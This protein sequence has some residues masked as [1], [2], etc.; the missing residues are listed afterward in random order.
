VKFIHFALAIALMAAAGTFAYH[1]AQ[2]VS[3]NYMLGDIEMPLALFALLCF[4]VGALFTALL[5]VPHLL[6][7][8][9]RIRRANRACR[10]QERELQSLRKMPLEGAVTAE[11]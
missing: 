11:N 6:R 10:E 4:V 7:S 5:M 9:Q 3:L 2:S 1:N 8:R